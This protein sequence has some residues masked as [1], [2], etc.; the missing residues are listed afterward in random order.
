VIT[1]NETTK[2]VEDSASRPGDRQ[3]RASKGKKTAEDRKKNP[4]KRGGLRKNTPISEDEKK[5]SEK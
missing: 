3:E 4:P 1:T 5:N 2:E